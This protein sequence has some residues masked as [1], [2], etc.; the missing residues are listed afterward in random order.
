VSMPI[1]CQMLDQFKNICVGEVSLFL[2]IYQFKQIVMNMLD[3]LHLTEKPIVYKIMGRGPRTM[4][5][6]SGPLYSVS[7]HLT[8]DAGISLC[9]DTVIRRCFMA[10]PIRQ[11]ESDDDTSSHMN[12]KGFSS[13]LHVGVKSR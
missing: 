13:F 6:Y 10:M 12:C 1:L 5:Y 7:N 3:C 4:V 9:A 2:F 11:I 8:L